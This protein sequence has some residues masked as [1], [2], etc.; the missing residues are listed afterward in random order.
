MRAP[1]PR[2]VAA[3]LCL[4]VI[5]GPLA[6][7]AQAQDLTP[8][9]LRRLALRAARD[10]SALA[11][12]RRAEGVAGKPV[13]FG[14]LLS[15]VRGDELTA[16]LQALVDGLEG[17]GAPP[18]LRPARAEARRILAGRGF[19]PQLFPRPLAGVLRRLGVWLTPAWRKVISA[20]RWAAGWL[21]GGRATL[22]AALAG[23]VV[24]GAVLLAVRVARRPRTGAGGGRASV[25]HP[26]GPGPARLERMADEAEV[27]GDAE[28]AVRLRFTAGLLRLGR[29][30]IIALHPSIT[31]GEVRRRLG[32]ET[33][34]SLATAFE[35][36]VYGGRRATA[37]DAA[38]ARRGW[39]EVRR[40]A[41]A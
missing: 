39:P 4:W 16:R 18:D 22:W 3:A 1:S 37:E 40:E 7:D 30:G 29:S 38:A 36:I 24:A 14:A 20:L 32:S 5:A 9:R 19:R 12:L 34:E 2:L 35:E 6:P 23:V 26:A 17:A 28:R 25:E 11:M 33:F 31:T 8:G 13:D 15:G 21:P 10:P 27:R 41:S